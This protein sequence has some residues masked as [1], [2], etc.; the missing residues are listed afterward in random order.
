METGEQINNPEV[1]QTKFDAMIVL[2]RNFVV[3]YDMKTLPQERTKLSPTSRI[4]V[5]AAGIMY[6][7][8][9]CDKI[10]F[11]TGYTA[12]SNMP[13]ESEAMRQHLLKIFKDIPEKDVLIEDVS[14]DTDTNAQEIR[15]II[16]QHPEFHNLGLLTDTTHLRRAE[17]VFKK[18]GMLVKPFDSL[19]VLGEKR[20]S[21]VERYV[22][23]ELYSKQA[24]RDKLG[25]IIQTIPI[26]KQI[27]SWAVH[28]GANKHNPY[29]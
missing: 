27:A 9:L 18:N 4:N 22:Q 16:D 26:A 25:N 7:Q 12:G 14:T 6:K 1:N 29:A 11:S 24:R 20:A 15:K 8:R 3:G 19:N 13:S 2:G 17:K 5:L 23:S 21:V 28:R 10:I